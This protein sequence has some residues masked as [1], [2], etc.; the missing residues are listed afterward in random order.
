MAA[1]D[2][3]KKPGR[4]GARPNAGG[5]RPGA[6]RPPAEVKS[7][8]ILVSIP[9]WAAAMLRALGGGS[10]SRGIVA[11]LEKLRAHE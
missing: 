2:Q 4:G 10:V 6:G 5:A 3:P 7:E 8:R 1:D 9:P 11:A